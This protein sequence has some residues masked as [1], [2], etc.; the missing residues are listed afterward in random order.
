M[1]IAAQ[2]KQQQKIRQR[3][4]A[5]AKMRRKAVLVRR[6]LMHNYGLS[7]VDHPE[8][9]SRVKEMLEFTKKK[10]HERAIKLGYVHL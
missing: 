9:S 7:S 2:S 1:R 6:W 8:F 10:R 3:R 4:Q 5:K